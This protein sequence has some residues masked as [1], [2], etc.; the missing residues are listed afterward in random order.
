[1]IGL[2]V[3][4]TGLIWI[5]FSVFSIDLKGAFVDLIWIGFSVFSINLN[6]ALVDLIFSTD[7][8]GALDGSIFLTPIV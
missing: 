1:M 6:G 3:L 7:C 5:G 8:T 4:L 2:F